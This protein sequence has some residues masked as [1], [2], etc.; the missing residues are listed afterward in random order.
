MITHEQGG[1]KALIQPLHHQEG[2]PRPA[3]DDLGAGRQDFAVDVAGRA[4]GIF[5]DD[6]VGPC[7]HGPFTGRQHFLCHFVA[8]IGI[9]G[10]A[11]A[12]ILVG[13]GGGHAFDV[14][15]D[16]YLHM[17]CSFRLVYYSSK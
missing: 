16:E 13:K 8:V 10:I 11:R 4:V 7:F 2:M 14:G 3:F 6:L 17:D 9:V 15:A 5:D 12:A 1:V